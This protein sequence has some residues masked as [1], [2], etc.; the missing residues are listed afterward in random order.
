MIQIFVNLITEGKKNLKEASQPLSRAT[1][2]PSSHCPSVVIDLSDEETVPLKSTSDHIVPQL[3]SKSS[4][5]QPYP[6]LKDRSDTLISEE[7]ASLKREM[8]KYH[9]PDLPS[10]RGMDAIV[11]LALSAALPAASALPNVKPKCPLNSLPVF[12]H[13]PYLLPFCAPVIDD[14]SNP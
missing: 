13:P 11:S 4:K 14:D 10:L 9:N 1:W 7:E 12:C 2:Q 5:I 3:R 6:D 8:A